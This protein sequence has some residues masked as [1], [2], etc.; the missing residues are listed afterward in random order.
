MPS[1]A[2]NADS[3]ASEISPLRGKKNELDD[4]YVF[5]RSITLAGTDIGDS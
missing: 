3:K 1:P 4:S 5:N 2:F